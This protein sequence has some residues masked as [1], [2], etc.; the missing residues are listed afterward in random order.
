MKRI[1]GAFSLMVLVSICSLVLG[2]KSYA[3]DKVINLK[4]AGGADGSGTYRSG[5]AIA[6]IV[7]KYSPRIKIFVQITPGTAVTPKM[8][9]AGQVDM[10]A[11]SQSGETES[12][13]GLELY[14]GNPVT[15]MSRLFV[16]GMSSYVIFS[17]AEKNIFTIRDLV[18]KRVGI[19]AKTQPTGKTCETV[20]QALGIAD[21]VK[22]SFNTSAEEIGERI[23][24]GIYDAGFYG[25]AMP[26]GVLSD[27]VQ[28]RKMRIIG[29]EG[30]DLDKAVA[31]VTPRY[32]KVIL[33]ANIY[34]DQKAFPTLGA[35]QT[36]C[37]RS[38]LDES[39]AYEIIKILET[40]FDEFVMAYPPSK[41]FFMEMNLQKMAV[42]PLHPAT[43]RWLK[44]KGVKAE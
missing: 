18:G 20:F 33:P 43:K 16:W 42:A 14:K 38:D 23:K 44:E 36:T 17:P 34:P 12:I 7:N 24:D 19:G 29:I 22:Y 39:V 6:S 30:E 26:W 11:G 2:M 40:H 4:Y 35:L 5:L 37:V 41:F 13:K 31:A 10:A 1:K 9:Q 27:L 8:I 32:G 28:T 21:K 3:A 25:V 15:N